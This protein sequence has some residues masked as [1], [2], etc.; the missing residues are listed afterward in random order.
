MIAETVNTNITDPETCKT[1]II[2][3]QSRRVLNVLTKENNYEKNVNISEDIHWSKSLEEMFDGDDLESSD[4]AYKMG[5][6]DFAGKVDYLYKSN[7]FLFGLG[8]GYKDGLFNHV[9]F[10]WNFSHIEFGAFTGV[11][12]QYNEMQYY[13]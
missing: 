10:G 2:N 5:G 6:L 13:G 9:T 12:H 4:A 11:Y 1:R 7:Y 8:A 3:Y